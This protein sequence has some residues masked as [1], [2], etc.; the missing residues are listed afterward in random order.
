VSNLTA[1]LRREGETSIKATT[2]TWSSS[3]IMTATF[4]IPNTTTVGP[5]DIVVTNPDGQ[6]GEFT[7]YFTVHGNKTLSS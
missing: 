3:S 4:D 6:S 2:V 5:W 1:L 7:N